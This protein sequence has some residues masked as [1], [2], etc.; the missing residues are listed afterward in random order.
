MSAAEQA[1]DALAASGDIV[2]ALTALE[3]ITATD[4]DRKHTW[5]KIAALRRA[6]GDL[7]GAIGAVDQMLR[8]APLDFMGLITRARLLEGLSRPAEAAQT[9]LHAL[10]QLPDGEAIPAQWVAIVTHARTVGDAFRDEAA[11]SLRRV[12]DA[13]PPIEPTMRHRLDRLATNSLRMTRV[14]HSDPTHCHYP[15]LVEREFHDRAGFSWLEEL[16]TRTDAIRDEYLALVRHSGARA[17]PYVQ[18]APGLPVRQWK[19]LNHSSDWTAFH[20]LHNGDYVAANAERCPQT[21]AALAPVDQPM[22]R[23]RSPNA[24]FSLLKPMTRIP[25][26]TGV[27]NTRLVCH[28]PLIVPDGCWFRVGAETRYWREG[29]AFVFD[30]TIEHEA[31]NDSYSPRVVLIFDLWHP[32][33]SAAERVGVATIMEAGADGSGAAL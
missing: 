22:I 15:G 5:L 1:A 8:I 16:E 3:Y 27:A 9:Y 7:T 30:D 18:Y 12:L 26:H 33:L 23:S 11:R 25:P 21:L 14:Y 28:L 32:A 4:P 6:G 17:E 13:L 2:G 31:A 29:E 10:A 19:A 24:M 20:I